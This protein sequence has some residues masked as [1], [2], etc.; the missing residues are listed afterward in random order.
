MFADLIFGGPS[1][2]S[3]REKPANTAEAAL[4]IGRR[5]VMKRK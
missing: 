4:G 5:M 2:S 3:K 1:A